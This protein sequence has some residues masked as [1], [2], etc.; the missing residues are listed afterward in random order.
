MSPTCVPKQAYSGSPEADQRHVV[1]DRVVLDQE[2]CFI[3]VSAHDRVDF[4]AYEEA[5]NLSDKGSR[6]AYGN[7]DCCDGV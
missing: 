4:Q 1:G 7:K 5:R 2:E 6:K 3:S